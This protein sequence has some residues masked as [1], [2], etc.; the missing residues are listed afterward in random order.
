[1]VTFND[2]WQLLYEHGS[3]SYYKHDCAELWESLTPEQQQKLHENISKRLQNNS[4]VAYNPLEAI[5]DNLPRRQPRSIG[6]PTDWNGKRAPEET[7]IACWNGHWGMYTVTDI[8]LY[9]LE[10]KKK[11]TNGQP[12]MAGN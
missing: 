6:T 3:T 7:E 8:E 12:C 10:T 4:Y 2:L 9:K 5:H 1:M 11:K